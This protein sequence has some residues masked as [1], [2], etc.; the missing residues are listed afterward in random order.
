M[1][2]SLK[3]VKKGHPALSEDPVPRPEPGPGK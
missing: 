1:N 2:A 3:Q